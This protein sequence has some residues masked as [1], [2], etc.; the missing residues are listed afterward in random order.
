VLD[1]PKRVAYRTRFTPQATRRIPGTPP[2]LAKP[3]ARTQ[4][5]SLGTQVIQGL[6]ADGKRVS[7]NVTPESKGSPVVITTETWWSRDLLIDL[8]LR[9]N[10]PRR[11]QSTVELNNIKRLEPNPELFRVPSDYAVVDSN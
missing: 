4:I 6:L 1:I 3:T 5:E 7:T 10:D 9:L 11:G 2:L 8:V